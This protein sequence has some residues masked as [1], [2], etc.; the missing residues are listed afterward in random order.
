MGT[1]NGF[2]AEEARADEAAWKAAWRR[3]RCASGTCK[4][5]Q[6]NADAEWPAA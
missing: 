1:R 5:A 2:E 6:D 3:R 4:K